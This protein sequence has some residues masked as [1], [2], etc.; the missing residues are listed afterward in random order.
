MYELAIIIPAY[1]DAYLD[2]TLLS[3]ASQTVR[4]FTVYVGDDNSPYDL[5]SICDKYKSLFPL[6]YHRFTENIGGKDLVKQWER[7]VSLKEEEKWIWLFSDDDIAEAHCVESFFSALKTTN[8]QYDVYRFDTIT[9]DQHDGLIAESEYSPVWEDAMS[10]A[11]N[12]LLSRRG[13]TMPDQI[14]QDRAYREW[15]GFVNFYFAQAA[16]WATTIN[17]AY[18]KGLYTIKGPR[19]QWRLSGSNVSSQASAQKSKMIYGHLQFIDWINKRFTAADEQ[20]YGITRAQIREASLVNL[21]YIIESHYHGIPYNG[22]L[23][24]VRKVDQ[25]YQLGWAASFRLCLGI[26]Y[27]LALYNLKVGLKPWFVKARLIDP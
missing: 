2:K 16:D 4:D 8:G 26:N 27:R 9:I 5:E 1:K 13:N 6:C 15:G 14:F 22:F 18:K 12:I 24:I 7:C 10:L 19:I 21:R 3:L 11:Y 17:F 23:K 20:S 25:I